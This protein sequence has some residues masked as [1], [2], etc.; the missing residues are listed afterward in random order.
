MI[1]SRIREAREALNL[2]RKGFGEKIFLSQDVIN[3]LERE[4]VQP[5]E[6][7]IKAICKQ[8]NVNEHWL[9]TGEGEM[10]NPKPVSLDAMAE[11]NQIDGLTRIVVESLLE[12][13]PKQ[14]EAFIALVHSIAEKVRNADYD[15]AQAMAVDAAIRYGAAI[16]VAKA[17]DQQGE[18]AQTE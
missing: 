6:F 3:N 11:A 1:G 4:R 13:K 5:T 8:Y 12:M 2:T 10:F 14:R 18:A 17:Q 15:G 16:N 7:H 9:R